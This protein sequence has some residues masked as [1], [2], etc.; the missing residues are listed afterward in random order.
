[1][2]PFTSMRDLFADYIGNYLKKFFKDRF[3]N[4]KEIK[5]VYCPTLIIHGKMDK[6]IN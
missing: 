4:L 2:S 1:M 3:N 5:E 6:L